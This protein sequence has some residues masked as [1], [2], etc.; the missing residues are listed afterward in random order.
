PPSAVPR[1]PD[2]QRQRLLRAGA[3]GQAHGGGVFLDGRL[4]AATTARAPSRQWPWHRLRIL[5]GAPIRTFA[6]A[7][8]MQAFVGCRIRLPS[9]ANVLRRRP[10]ADASPLISRLGA[11][12]P[13]VAAAQRFWAQS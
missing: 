6:G 7:S 5:A 1:Q 9:G 13:G 11:T 10:L 4:S 2:P 8:V 12:A 3:G